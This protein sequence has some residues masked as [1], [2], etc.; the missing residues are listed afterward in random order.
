MAR[1]N[2]ARRHG[3]DFQARLFWLNAASLL[4][5]NSPVIKVAYETGPK[6]FDDIM[7]E[8][9]PRAAPQDH[10]GKPIYLMHIQCKWHT[11]AGVFGYADLIDPAFI[12]AERFSLL[13]KVYQA[14]QRHAPDGLGCR[15]ELKTNWRLKPDDP[16]L[17]LVRKESDALDLDLLFDGSTDRSRMGRVRKL[18]CEHLG[19]DYTDLKLVA[20]VLAIAETPESLAGLR[21]RLDDKFA[22]VGMKRVP[23]AE[24]GFLYDDLA[25][26][27][28][29][30]GR[31]KFDRKS[32]R[33]MA[34][35]E[36]L[37][38]ASGARS[39]ALAIGIRSFMH[40]ID[41]LENRCHRMLNLVPYFE[42]RYMRNE[43]DW[44]DRILP[45]LRAFVLKAARSSDHLQLV[46]DAHASLAFALG[47]L[48]NVKSGKHIEIEQRTGGRRFWSMEDRPPDHDWP[49][50]AFEE[51]I[52]D[53]GSDE[54]ALAISLTYDVSAAV[55]GFVGRQAP[56][57]GRIIYC[58]PQGGASQQSVRCGRHAWMLAESA[59]QR[60]RHLRGGGAGAGLL[61][62]FIAG[63]NA[64]S[65]FLGQHQQA[66][67]PAALYEWDFD[68]QR[69]GGYSIGLL[70]GGHG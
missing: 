17:R 1:S 5:P 32:F 37:L 33:A 47:T 2:V 59:V 63:P 12:G 41:A 44:Q 42:G 49:A 62:V 4:D 39:D 54:A 30:Q 58:R 29:A 11:T 48:L 8:Y 14:Q 68:C 20:R 18:W 24:A 70:I 16:L 56:R 38:D 57:I 3:D 15:F 60:I 25:A 46:V 52:L 66:L 35:H 27:L 65:F 53:T 10:E 13:D 19:L 36:G 21:E 31:T 6:S 26:K 69:D 22:A 23:A 7:V 34:V 28:L 61:H 9:D 50:F 43:A 51:E 67:G 40:P 64:F 55:R 45:A